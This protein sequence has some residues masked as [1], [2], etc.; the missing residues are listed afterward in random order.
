MNE[1][2][3]DRLGDAL[4]RLRED[5]AGQA[6]PAALEGKLLEAFRAHHQGADRNPRR[7]TWISLAIAASLVLA[8]ASRLSQPIDVEAPVVP[9]AQAPMR[10]PTIERVAGQPQPQQQPKPKPSRKRRNA[11]TFGPRMS[12]ASNQAFTEIPYAPPFSPQEG[13]QIV[14]VNMPGASARRMG[15]PVLLDRVQADLL[16][17]NDG[18]PRAIRLV[19]DSGTQYH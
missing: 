5:A 1:P 6:P 19:S 13:G 8:V 10:N 3:Q 14:R 18:L 17:G 11:R 12:L 9:V 4:R 15:V 2:M 16:V 7:W